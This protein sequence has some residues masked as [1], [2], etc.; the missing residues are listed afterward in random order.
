[1][2]RLRHQL[3]VHSPIPPASLVRGIFLGPGASPGPIDE[4]ASV[5]ADRFAA[6]RV[7][8]T[9][10]GTQ[11]LNL[12]IRAGLEGAGGS[13]AVA[14]PGFCCYDI[15]SA[16][17]GADARIALYD[18]DPVTLTPDL[19]SVESVLESTG[20]KALVVAHLYGFPGDWEKLQAIASRFGAV[21]IED[22]AQ[23]HGGSWRGRPLG[24][25][26]GLS[27]MS[28][29]RGKGWTGSGGGALLLRDGWESIAI[30][31]PSSGGTGWKILVGGFAHWALGRPEVYGLPASLPWLGLGET[32][33]HPPTQPVGMHPVAAAVALRSDSNSE[34]EAE[35]RRRSATRLIADLRPIPAVRPIDGLPGAEPGYLR[36]PVRLSLGL[37]S[38][39][40][41]GEALRLG[42]GRSYPTTLDAL[43]VV[44]ERLVDSPRIPGAASLARQLVTL[45]VHSLVREAERESLIG[46]LRQIPSE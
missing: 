30:S 37:E 22:A 41:P 9:G 28:F 17:V 43:S 11:A 10:S 6:R 5:L 46:L 27:V 14:L 38:F 13:R 36:L 45:P 44:T 23:G 34:R 32:R 3:P 42:V 12:A 29:G 39:P 24:S 18:V 8:L 2:I 4:L 19:D 20:A 16:A 21:L 33:Y 25:L 1:M 7:V 40:L 15:A 35:T 31:G 26:G